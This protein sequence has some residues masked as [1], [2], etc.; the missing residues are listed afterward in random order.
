M[1][2]FPTARILCSLAFAALAAGAVAPAQAGVS[3]SIGI[4]APIAPGV[5]VGTVISDGR[6]GMV[7]VPVYAPEPVYMPAPVYVPRRVVMAAPV[8]APGWRGHGE[9][10]HWRH[11]GWREGEWQ[12]EHRPVAWQGEHRR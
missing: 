7:G 12:R 8:W 9:R 4:Q 11:E 1:P 5:S 6:P 10:E 3:W 2:R